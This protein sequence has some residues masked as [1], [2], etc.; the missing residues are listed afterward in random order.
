[1]DK[2]NRCV[3]AVSVSLFLFM[4]AST[5]LNSFFGCTLDCECEEY[6]I[7]NNRNAI[8]ELNITD[9][10]GDELEI[11]VPPISQT[12]HAMKVVA[13]GEACIDHVCLAGVVPCCKVG[14]TCTGGFPPPFNSIEVK[15]C[16]ITIN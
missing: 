7:Y 6:T 11:R 3:L 14:Y 2:F 4:T 1:M 12:G 15:D 16:E 8:A 10:N 9:C 13:P 5:D